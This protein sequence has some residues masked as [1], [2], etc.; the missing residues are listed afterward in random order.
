[1][2]FHVGTY[3]IRGSQGIYRCALDPA[4]GAIEILGVT[5]DIPNPSFLAIHPNGELLYSVSEVRQQ[6]MRSRGAVYALRVERRSGELDRINDRPSGGR[7]PCHVAV[8]PDGVWVA[9][10]NYASGSVVLFSVESDGSLSEAVSVVQHQGSSVHPQRQQGPH[11]HSCTFSSDS[12]LLYV[13]DL[14]LDR[15]MV[16]CI[17]REAGLGLADPPWFRTQAGAGP[18]HFDFHPAEPFAY[19]INEIDSTITAVRREPSTGALRQVACYSTLP[20][21]FEGENS[22]ADVHVHPCGRFVYGSN[23]GHDSIVGFTIDTSTGKLANPRWWPTHG[24]NP[25]NFTIAPGGRFLLAANQD[26]DDIVVF[27]ID[28]VTGSLTPTGHTC[29]IPAPVCVR[30]GQITVD[31]RGGRA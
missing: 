1:M 25:R 6:G 5:T 13:A 24:P 26:G 31:G 9:A 23:R 19:L 14:G 4:S 28:P 12:G 15:L 27:S 22:T 30:F 29:N 16:Y 7:G 3:T 10:A 2:N 21:G 17:D 8:S 11:A 20:L 18:R